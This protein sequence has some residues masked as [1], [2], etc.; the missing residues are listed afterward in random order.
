[1]EN[2]DGPQGNLL[3]FSCIGC[4][5]RTFNGSDGRASSIGGPSA[6]QVGPMAAPPAGPLI[7]G[8]YFSTSSDASTHNVADIPSTAPDSVLMLKTASAPGGSF[9]LQN[10][11]KPK[12][13]CDSCHDPAVRHSAAGSVRSGTA[14]SSYRMLHGTTGNQY[15]KGTGD[16]DFEAGTG[17]NQYD[18]ASMNLFCA[19]C[20]GL[21]HGSAGTSSGGAWV[22]HPTDVTTNSY[23]ANYIGGDKVVPVGDA[24]LTADGH[25]NQVMCLSCHRAHGNASPDM[26]RFN[27]SG[28]DNRAGDNTASQGCETCHGDK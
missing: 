13:R 19:N 18:A 15:V 27:Y 2:T 16:V 8:G 14:G 22:R 11:T 4:H 24:G 7:S 3:K 12:L 9:A 5:A 1:M 20:H 25:T 23:G 6:P 26:L 28:A 17:Q 21:F 10:G